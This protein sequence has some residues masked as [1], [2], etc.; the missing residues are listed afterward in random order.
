VPL[1]YTISCAHND[2][3]MQLIIKRLDRGIRNCGWPPIP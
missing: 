3:T 2:F 1:D